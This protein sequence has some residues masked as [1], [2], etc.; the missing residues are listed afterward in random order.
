MA[1]FHSS[2]IEPSARDLFLSTLRSLAIAPEPSLRRRAGIS[3]R[4]VDLED[5]I[6][7]NSFLTNSSLIDDSFL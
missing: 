1:C 7:F 6:F 5:F 3:A 4:A 2:G